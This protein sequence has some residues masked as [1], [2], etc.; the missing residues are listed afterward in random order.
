MG[1]PWGTWGAYLKMPLFF[2]KSE[3]LFSQFT[4]P[5]KKSFVRDDINVMSQLFLELQCAAKKA[6][7]VAYIQL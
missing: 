1:H 4:K 7:T 5:F 3:C 2:E 6:T